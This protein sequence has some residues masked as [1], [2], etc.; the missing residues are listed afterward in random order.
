MK[1]K[2]IC[3]Y[4]DKEFNVYTWGSHTF[5]CEKNPKNIKKSLEKTEIKKIVRRKAKK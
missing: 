5:V 1:I 3:P 4:C 2:Y